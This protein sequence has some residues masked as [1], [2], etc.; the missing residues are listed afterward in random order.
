[1]LVVV[2]DDEKD[3]DNDDN[4]EHIKKLVDSQ[5]LKIPSLHGLFI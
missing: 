5:R 2:D 3:N 1:M 4:G